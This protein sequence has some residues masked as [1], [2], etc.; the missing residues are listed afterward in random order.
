MTG[1]IAEAYYKKIPQRLVDIGWEML[2][3]RLKNVVNAIDTLRP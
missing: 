3:E 1:G 2:P